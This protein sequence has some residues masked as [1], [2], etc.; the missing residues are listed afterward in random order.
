M[1]AT[2]RCLLFFLF[3]TIT[4]TPSA[5][6]A[7]LE[8]GDDAKDQ[9]GASLPSDPIFEAFLTDGSIASGPILELGPG[10]QLTIGSQDEKRVISFDQLVKLTRPEMSVPYPPSGTLLILPDGDRLRALIHTADEQGFRITSEI[11]GEMEIPLESAIGL[12]LAPPAVSEER[13]NLLIRV[14]Q[15]ARENDLFWLTNNDRRSGTF[16]EINSRRVS[17]QLGE[18]MVEIPRSDLRAIG[19]DPALANYPKPKGTYLELTLADGSRLGVI[20]PSLEQ[21]ELLAT[22][23]F[24]AKVQIPI[25]DLARIHWVGGSVSYLSDREAAGDQYVSYIGPTRPYQRDASVLGLPLRV[26][27]EFYDRGIGTQSRSLLAYRLE[28]EDRRFQALVGLDEQAGSLGNVV[29][30]VLVD[31]E[32][33]FASPPLS[34]DDDPIAIDLDVSEARLLILITE[35]GLR[36]GVRDYANWAEARLVR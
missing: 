7:L 27:G 14:Q 26:S 9:P 19:F 35:F 22:T 8:S 5:S 3:A 6:P 34:I 25:R 1:I 10:E 11:F 21:G 16:F 33:Q 2:L 17:F 36:G 30:K 12:I 32:E 24:G 13:L 4:I 23:R 28:P 31:G 18:K 29:F 15:D 20:T